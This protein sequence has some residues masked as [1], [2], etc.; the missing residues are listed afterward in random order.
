MWPIRNS[1]EVSKFIDLFLCELVGST[2]IADMGLPFNKHDLLVMLSYRK[3]TRSR[4]LKDIILLIEK[5]PTVLES[6]RE[7]IRYHH[8]RFKSGHLCYSLAPIG[9]WRR[10]I[11]SIILN[12]ISHRLQI[13]LLL[14]GNTKVGKA[15]FM[16]S[17]AS[18]E[19]RRT[20]SSLYL[21]KS[22][23][24]LQTFKKIINIAFTM[25]APSTFPKKRH[26]IVVTIDSRVPSRPSYRLGPLSMDYVIGHGRPIERECFAG[27]EGS[28]QALWDSSNVMNAWLTHPITLR[29]IVEM[30]TVILIR[31][32]YIRE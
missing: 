8:F 22:L 15:R 23:I 9:H 4:R 12:Y 26:L 21:R 19:Q 14:C 10:F 2:C 24:G 1:E 18:H 27:H 30:E 31:S 20:R 7:S 16:Y 25:Q 3:R 5:R 28:N 17:H 32:L 11:S 6:P 13:N 29:M